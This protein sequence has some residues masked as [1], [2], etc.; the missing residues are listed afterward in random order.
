MEKTDPIFRSKLEEVVSLFPNRALFLKRYKEEGESHPSM[1]PDETLSL[2][3]LHKYLA[4]GGSKPKIKRK[5]NL[6]M[7]MAGLEDGS[8]PVVAA[9]KPLLIGVPYSII[10]LPIMKLILRKGK[11]WPFNITPYKD[12]MGHPM[13]K[14]AR[15]DLVSEIESE[16]KF[17]E[18]LRVNSPSSVVDRFY[19]DSELKEL[20][21]GGEI[22]VLVQTSHSPIP[23]N[24]IK[25]GSYGNA[26]NGIVQCAVFGNLALNDEV[27]E[28]NNQEGRKSYSFEDI[29]KGL[30][31][32]AK[33]PIFRYE[34]TSGDE[35]KNHFSW[36]F[37]NHY[38]NRYQA[39]IIKEKSFELDTKELVGMNFQ[40][41]C[42]SILG[43]LGDTTTQLSNDYN[44]IKKDF[45]RRVIE[46]L[47]DPENPTKVFFVLLSPPMINWILDT[48][49]EDNNK[50][51]G[52]QVQ[53]LSEFFPKA[54]EVHT[55]IN[56]FVS[57]TTKKKKQILYFMER[58]GDK[59]EELNKRF[60]DYFPDL[61]QTYSSYKNHIDKQ[62]NFFYYIRRYLGLSYD[63]ILPLYPKIQFRL[64]YTRDGLDFFS[65][66]QTKE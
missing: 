33:L 13:Y 15:E 55:N 21:E 28:R 26:T 37:Y 5:R 65:S 61:W 34:K 62:S 44:Q 2:G 51:M 54:P 36:F 29:V 64:M 6:Q 35:N 59:I 53:E 4:I 18:C 47:N 12:S 3:T 45:S 39:R 10:S 16:D 25:I 57:K 20:F 58:L 22:D 8:F 38:F 1:Y 42:Q 19:T 52:I 11:N 66:I 43:G 56:I 24:S 41:I 63:C 17:F 49:R 32:Q 50:N 14:D 60:D 40:N 30:P 46:I 9:P 27:L 31:N 7:F 23:S 48:F